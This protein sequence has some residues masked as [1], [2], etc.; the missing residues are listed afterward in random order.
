VGSRFSG[1]VRATLLAGLLLVVV[2]SAAVAAAPSNRGGQLTA[3]GARLLSSAAEPPPQPRNLPGK[4][5]NLEVV[6]RLQIPGVRESQIADLAVYKGFAY[7]NSW[8]D[9]LCR[10]G[11]TYVVDIR[12][13]GSP[14]LVRH[15]PADQP[16]YH[17]EGA[18]VITVNTPAFQGD[19][20]AVNN[21]TY[22]S[23]VGLE[24]VSPA[25][26]TCLPADREAPAQG[27]VDLSGGGFDLYDVSNPA[28]PVPLVRNAGDL[29]PD[30]EGPD[31][32][33][34]F[35]NSY[36]SVFVWQDG[37]RAFLVA[38]DN[39]EETDVD[40]FDITN[41]RAPV[42][43][44]DHSLEQRF[45]Q[46]MNG[47]QGNGRSVFHH[48]VV[49]KQ[50]GGRP[51]MKVDNWDAGYV[52]LDVTDP[53]N[54]RLINDTTFAGEDPLFPGGG[55]PPEGNAHQGEFSFDN[56]FLL[57][58]DED[59]GPFRTFARS[60]S[61]DTAGR[62]AT[63]AEGGD[64][65]VRIVNLPDG[66]M[67]GPSMFVGD[68]CTAASIPLAPADDGDPNTDDIAL[69]ERGGAG[70]GCTF[71][72]K[73][74]NAAA[75]NWDGVVIFN[76]PRPDDGLVNM[77]TED[78]DGPP[79]IP[80]VHMRRVDALGPSGVLSS[81]T[82]TPPPTTPG[83]D[84]SVRV[85]FDGWGYAHLYDAQTAQPID[86]FAIDEALDPRFA[87]GFGVLSIHEFATD[88]T[89]HLAYSSYYAGGIRVFQFSRQNGL[90]ETGAWI[91]DGGSDFW[92]VEQFTTPQGER[93][94]GGSDRDFGLVILRYTGPGA[95]QRPAC[96]DVTVMVGFRDSAGVPFACTDANNNPLRQS[97][98]STP[99]NGTIA[100]R[101]PNGGWTYTH[102]GNSLGPAG[103]FTYR[104]NDGAAD[105]NVAT[106]NLVAVARE[107]GRCFNPFVGSAARDLIIGSRFGDR[108]S[109]GRGRDT[110]QARAGDDCVRG[111]TAS[112]RLAGERG[113][114]RLTGNRG[115]DR[116]F[117]GPG[118]DRMSGGPGNDGLGGRAGNDRLLGGRGEDRIIAGAG[119]DRLSAGRGR[120]R[121]NGGRGN[122]RLRSRNGKIDRV[123]CGRGRDRVTADENDRVAENC[124]RVR[125]R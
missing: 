83:P 27:L 71:A 40:I 36:H 93:L 57:A 63:V 21:E 81:S 105:S 58:A 2:G 59:F 47:E 118:R 96:S 55:L 123:I 90:N 102:T 51:V 48:D 18:H 89:E 20:L 122:D 97:R 53:A 28:N 67:N 121:L 13:P 86:H 49:V 25:E 95:A 14:Q 56:Q 29:D 3:D 38:S 62:Q 37:P 6:G 26:F 76:Q 33:R 110:V 91:A 72:D 106:A 78:A 16:Y 7:L 52:Q 92:G 22:G 100:D 115:A 120:N 1:A 68:G 109:G 50:I 23:N 103:S 82:T 124:E 108:I 64:N 116:L 5:E 45:P 15:I 73:F 87:D 99:Q 70:G 35:A 46:I 43:V 9:P 119:N 88:P 80:G 114:D 117:G 79:T 125:R 4:Q 60:E 17:G 30:N 77:A 8:D 74:D 85:Q 84:L 41:P 66:L 65:P 107:G 69:I 19:I 94:I 54:P 31:P 39:I 12:N 34:D 44:G 111:G 11:G 104:A 112:D 42:Q 32:P 61:G 101:P 24:I 113:R 75:R 98:L 10:D